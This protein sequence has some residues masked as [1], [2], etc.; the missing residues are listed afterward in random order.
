M[1]NACIS[2]VWGVDLQGLL[3]AAHTAETW[4]PKNGAGIWRVSGLLMRLAGNGLGPQDLAP[5]FKIIE[6]AALSVL[7]GS[8][9]WAQSLGGAGT[10]AGT[11]TDASSAAV[12]SVALRF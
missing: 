5:R 3:L 7:F 8:L 11:V 1:R 2:I 10:V 6:I 9:D 4:S 12:P